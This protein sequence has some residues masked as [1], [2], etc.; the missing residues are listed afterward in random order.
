MAVKAYMLAQERA[1]ETGKELITASIIRSVCKDKFKIIRPALDALKSKTKNALARFE[2]AYPKFLGQYIEQSAK[3]PESDSSSGS[4]K[5]EGE[6]ASDPVIRAAMKKA[7][8]SE[9]PNKSTSDNTESELIDE[10][11]TS[12]MNIEVWFKK[13]K[14]TQAASESKKA[15]LP[16]ILA[17][18][19]KVDN[20]AIHAALN[21][22]G[23]I[24]SSDEFMSGG[25]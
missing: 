21:E 23:F 19:K 5:V 8:Q 16:K 1:I 14:K 3:V 24:R 11:Q 7:E 13:S 20:K 2:D 12:L 17:S 25:I 4:V 10:K 18:L 9:K 6:I 22:A 15:G